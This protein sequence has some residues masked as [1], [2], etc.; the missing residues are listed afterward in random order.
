MNYFGAR[1]TRNYQ[2]IEDQSNSPSVMSY[3]DDE[4]RF[5]FCGK[6]FPRKEEELIEDETTCVKVPHRIGRSILLCGKKSS[7]FPYQLFVS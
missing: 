1:D 5:Y 7:H 6:S 3:H 4:K 2:T